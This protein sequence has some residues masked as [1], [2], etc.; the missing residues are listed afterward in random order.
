MKTII[1]IIGGFLIL[2]GLG[3][4]IYPAENGYDLLFGDDDFNELAIK[5]DLDIPSFNFGCIYSEEGE[6]ATCELND[7]G[8]TTIEGEAKLPV[9]NY[10]VEIPH[11]ANPEILV[12]S[13]TW[14][15]TSLSELNLPSRIM[16][17][18]PSI[19]K[20]RHDFE[21]VEFSFNSNYYTKNKF[22]PTDIAKII[23]TGEVRGRRFALVQISPVQYNPATGELNIITSCELKIDL[24][25]SD[26]VK[27]YETIEHYS[28]P[29][30]DDLF[31][32]LFVNYDEFEGNIRSS[33]KGDNGYLI[34]VFDDFYDEIAPL[35]NWKQ[36]IGY[37][38]TVTKT[39]Q[40][41]GG[42]TKENIYNYIEDA[43][44][45]WSI[46]PAYVLLVGDTAQIPT[47]TGQSSNTAADLYYVTVDGSD[48]FPDI[49]IGR[50]PASQASHV[51]VMV[52]KTIGYE[53]GEFASSDFLLKA[54]FMA[55]TDNYQISEG[56][57]NYVISNYFEPLGYQCDKLYTVTYG[58][59]TQ[60]VRNSFN[61]G[62]CLAVY[63]G[64]GGTTSWAD[65]PPFSQSDVRGLTNQGMLSFVCSH[66]C[67]TGKF[68]V[69]ECFGETW[70]RTA[71]K[72]AIVF[73][74]SSANTL[75]DEDD[76]LE[77]KTLAEWDDFPPIGSMTDKGLYGLYQYYGGGGYSKYYFECYN[78][79]GDPS[80]TIGYS[81]SGN[82]GDH[83]PP[84]VGITYPSQDDIICGTINISG[85]A[86][87]IDGGKIK[88]VFIQIGND[89]WKEV[90]GTDDW[91]YT[92]NSTAV[93]D[94]SI[95]ISAVSIDNDGDQ[96]GVDYIT[97]TVKNTPDPPPKYP[98]LHCDGN[99]CWTDVEPGSLV[100]DSFELENIGDSGSLL[101]WEITEHPEDW[102]TWTLNPSSGEDLKPED[103][104]VTV[105]VNVLVPD[106]QEKNYTG[107][108]KI[109]N[110]DN[111]SDYEIIQI[112]LATP[113]NKQSIMS[114]FIHFLEKFIKRFPLLNNLFSLQ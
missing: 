59:T 86:Y 54:V 67:V 91:T 95:L 35:A 57:H 90:E 48:Y 6:F 94:G 102:G 33:S 112:S 40:I 97:I 114:P 58:A 93:P 43:Y 81:H 108:I 74:G 53:S 79:L 80:I 18:Q 32:D 77:K 12:A 66:A 2:S 17:V 64:H 19:S 45:T 60:D 71:N 49:F 89:D 47:F 23:E 16:P 38:V 14:I 9:I 13:D 99:L 103:G 78:I 63:S 75:W 29:D 56:T 87:S 83:R 52:D 69:G 28:S 105:Q 7:E 21:E 101:N 96:S 61:E 85:Y 109:V 42:P 55:S 39:S 68:T 1:L 76:I 111:T 51:T 5:I 106:E 8:F 31:R 50:F 11:G 15:F 107:Q 88:Y 44:D 4:A 62:R 36:S 34:I 26:M 46:P 82:G 41:P 92:W 98:D 104:T 100:T 24:P 10:M 3:A 20:A 70:M 84:R 30:F 110:K 27:T 37:D 65:G 25:G 72:A 113:K 73:W 22:M